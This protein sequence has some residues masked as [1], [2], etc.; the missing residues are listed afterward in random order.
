MD[1]GITPNMNT[2]RTA[3]CYRCQ[4]RLPERLVA[5][6]PGPRGGVDAVCA[7]CMPSIGDT[8]RD[9]V[10]AIRRARLAPSPAQSEPESEGQ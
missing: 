9:E 10:I 7:A 6:I 5:Y 8:L 3:I 4:M 2:E 1:I